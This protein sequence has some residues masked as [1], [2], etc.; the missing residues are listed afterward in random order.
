MHKQ[1]FSVLLHS[2]RKVDSVPEQ[3]VPG[4]LLADDPRGNRPAVDADPQRQLFVW[5]V[6]GEKKR[7]IFN[8]WSDFYSLWLPLDKKSFFSTAFLNCW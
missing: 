8:S 3:A 6:P 7:T 1:T 2:R 4:H 5:S